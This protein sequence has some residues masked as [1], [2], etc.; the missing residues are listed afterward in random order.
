MVPQTRVRVHQLR[1]EKSLTQSIMK[2][3]QPIELFTVSLLTEPEHHFPCRNHEPNLIDIHF[4]LLYFSELFHLR[5]LLQVGGL[6]DIDR[7]EV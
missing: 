2:I 5:G 7:V 6:L 3:T 1:R 4:F